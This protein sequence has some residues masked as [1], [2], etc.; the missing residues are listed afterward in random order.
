MAIPRRSSRGLRSLMPM[1][2]IVASLGFVACGDSDSDS[3]S[4]ETPAAQ[5]TTQSTATQSPGVEEAKKFVADNSEA[6]TSI[7]DLQPV[8][9]KPPSGKSI[10]YLSC[11][12]P[13]CTLIGQGVKAATDALGWEYKELVAGGSP[14]TVANAWNQALRLQPD[15]VL[16]VAAPT[17]LYEK[18]QK[19]LGEKAIGHVAQAV[20]D[21]LGDGL[22]AVISS[23]KNYI[24]RGEW[25]ANY[26]VA[27][28]DGKADVLYFTT[29]DFPIVTPSLE[30]FTNEL[31]RLC[32]SCS[33]ESQEV[34]LTDIG[35]KLPNT[36][37]TAAQRNPDANYVVVPFGDMTI[38]VPQALE[39]AGLADKVKV[40]SAN[41][42]LTNL[43][44][45]SSGTAE[46]A[47]VAEA[48]QVSGWQMVD[49][50]VRS[51]TGDDLPLDVYE[52]L[53]EHQ[54]LTAD[55]IGDPKQPYP[56]PDG[57]EDMFRELWKLG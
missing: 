49:P 37:V 50:V 29:P 42:A 2:I 7:G 46:V 13:L 20:S 47:S 8:S 15:A 43:D 27:D 11:G 24:A 45:I 4:A 10:V 31:K 25:M 12:V 1:A 28:T 22:I 53:P 41:P 3:G 33:V 17:V 40:I 57:Y 48:N 21:P 54:F 14:E 56:G 55:N 5:E 39:A 6:P 52:L 19:E 34:P 44:N 30:G 9:K 36:I 51:L 23:A 38:G 26:V 35:K 32:E 16:S 18:Q